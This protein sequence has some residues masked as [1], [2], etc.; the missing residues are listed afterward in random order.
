MLKL[1]HLIGLPLIVNGSGKTVGK[2]KDIWFDEHWQL[3]GIITGSRRW[4]RKG[5]YAVDWEDVLTC[6]KDALIVSRSDVV[7]L[8][9]A[10]EITR[11]YCWGESKLKDLP[12]ITT[13]GEELGR[14]SD[15]YFDPIKGTPIVGYELTDGFISDVMEG[16]HWL[17]VAQFADEITLGEKAVLVPESASHEL[18]NMTTSESDR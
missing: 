5:A 13:N 18:H 9:A 4:P 12:V 1:Q 6:G 10:G 16:R 2:V 15:V 11:C 14:I 3:R 8:L 7:R 17:R